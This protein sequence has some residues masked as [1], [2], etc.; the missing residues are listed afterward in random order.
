MC[1]LAVLG[2]SMS[3]CFACLG[4]LFDFWLVCY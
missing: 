1:R 3:V 4:V 2:F